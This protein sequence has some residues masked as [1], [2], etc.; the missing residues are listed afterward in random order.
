MRF[1][2]ALEVGLIEDGDFAFD[3]RPACVEDL[4]AGGLEF[5]LGGV[6][7]GEVALGVGH[8]FGVA[9]CGAGGAVE[10]AAD[11]PCCQIS[12]SAIHVGEEDFAG[13][14]FLGAVVPAAEEREVV[15]QGGEI[16]RGRGLRF[17]G[18]DEGGG[19]GFGVE[20]GSVS[21]IVRGDPL[22]LRPDRGIWDYVTPMLPLTT[23]L[24][25]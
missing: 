24:P 22:L 19:A 3:V 12:R 20:G 18:G 13:A 16:G 8:G 9:Q 2:A 21:G 14:L 25:I 15:A 6:A 1:P 17:E 7:L 11:G 10:D 4:G 5:G 23:S